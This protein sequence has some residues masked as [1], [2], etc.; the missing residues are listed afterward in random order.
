MRRGFSLVEVIIVIVILAILAA[1]AFP[2]FSQSKLKNDAIQAAMY[3]R[4]IRLAEQ[5]FFS[6]NATYRASADATAIRT[7][8]G[9]E[10]TTGTYSFDVVAGSTGTIT[11]S[12]LA[13]ARRGTVA[14]AN[15]TDADTLCVDQAGVWTGASTYRPAF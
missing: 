8:L 1:I 5:M 2:S 7:N 13:R 11:T 15:C 3:L 6:K 12:F 10:T 14:P 4:A 9:V